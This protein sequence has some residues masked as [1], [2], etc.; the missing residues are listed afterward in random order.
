MK[1]EV[2][3]E[4]KENTERNTGRVVWIK[5]RGEGLYQFLE[6]IKEQLNNEDGF[7]RIWKKYTTEDRNLKGG[8][9]SFEEKY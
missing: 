2:Y 3:D 8:Q 4:Y 6:K 9:F 1:L 7:K 5:K